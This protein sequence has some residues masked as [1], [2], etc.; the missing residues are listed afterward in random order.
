M[1]VCQTSPPV[2][3]CAKMYRGPASA[4]DHLCVVKSIHVRP[5]DSCGVRGEWQHASLPTQM[6]GFI[7]HAELHEFQCVRRHTSGG[8][9]RD[10]D[11]L[12]RPARRSKEFHGGLVPAEGLSTYSFSPSSKGKIR[13][14]RKHI[15]FGSAKLHEICT[16]GREF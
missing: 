8:R 4:R 6:A 10:R 3:G 15:E 14:S 9:W 7:L 16:H 5:Q 13:A 2:R 1:V 11:R 12:A